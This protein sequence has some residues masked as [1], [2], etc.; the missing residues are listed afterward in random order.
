MHQLIGSTPKH[1]ALNPLLNTT[2]QL[3]FSTQLINSNN[4]PLVINT[5]HQHNSST[6]LLLQLIN[7]SPDLNGSTLL[8]NSM[9]QLISWTQLI[10]LSQSTQLIN[11]TNHH[12]SSTQLVNSA[13]LMNTI[14]PVIK[15]EL[16]TTHILNIYELVSL[17]DDLF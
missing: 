9:H 2:H 7:T 6:L 10:H 14:N 12:N 15:V 4:P 17:V 11:T 1:N 16:I 5:T 8:S 3:N 13:H